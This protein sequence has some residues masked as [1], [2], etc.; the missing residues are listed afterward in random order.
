MIGDK[1]SGELDEKTKIMMNSY[2]LTEGKCVWKIQYDTTT[3]MP[4][5]MP[6]IQ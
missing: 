5:S 6:L 3:K 1:L 4:S 2:W